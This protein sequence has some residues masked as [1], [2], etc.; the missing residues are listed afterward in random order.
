MDWD[1][2]CQCWISMGVQPDP[3]PAP[4]CSNDT[5]LHESSYFIHCPLCVAFAYALAYSYCTVPD[6][7]WGKN[8]FN[9]LFWF[10]HSWQSN[11]RISVTL[12]GAVTDDMTF[13]CFDIWAL[14]DDSKA[15]KQCCCFFLNLAGS[16]HRCICKLYGSSLCQNTGVSKCCEFL[17]ILLIIILIPSQDAALLFTSYLSA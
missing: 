7:I 15:H 17:L 6:L 9:F 4:T 14:A 8:H 11:R 10:T 13:V 16:L 1:L 12:C 5:N 2:L 3:L